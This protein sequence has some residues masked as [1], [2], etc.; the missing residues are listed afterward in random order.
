[1]LIKKGIFYCPFTVTFG[2]Q[3]KVVEPPLEAFHRQP[4]TDRAPPQVMLPSQPASR[5]L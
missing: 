5:Y 2:E 4:V 3:R 1:M